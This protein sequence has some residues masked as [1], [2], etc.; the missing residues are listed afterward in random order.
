MLPDVKRLKLSSS[1]DRGTSTS[2]DTATR[3]ASIKEGLNLQKKLSRQ[4]DI[5]FSNLSEAVA[6]AAGAGQLATQA[7]Q[8]AWHVVDKV[9]FAKHCDFL[10]RGFLGS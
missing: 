2:S 3:V 8:E 4:Y 6:H 7:E 10:G 9:N 1:S 5:D